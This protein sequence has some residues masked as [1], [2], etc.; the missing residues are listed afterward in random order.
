MSDDEWADEGTCKCG[1]V[2]TLS[3]DLA[4]DVF[5]TAAPHRDY[6]THG[7]DTP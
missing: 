7:Y 4:V 6:C 1:Y 3:G 5:T 2:Y